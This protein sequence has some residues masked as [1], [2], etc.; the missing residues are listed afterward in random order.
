MADCILVSAASGYRWSPSV[1]AELSTS[2]YCGFAWRP[3]A[4]KGACSCV[5]ALG[6][7]VV[8]AP[9]RLGHDRRAHML[10]DFSLPRAAFSRS[11]WAYSALSMQALRQNILRLAGAAVWNYA[12][13][14]YPSLVFYSQPIFYAQPLA[15]FSVGSSVLV[16]APTRV[17]FPQL[18]HFWRGPYANCTRCRS[19]YSGSVEKSSARAATERHHRFFIKARAACCDIE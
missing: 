1:G 19:A 4:A 7:G 16:R 11:R 14:S 3:L 6:D 8:C 12:L 2:C 5:A 10:S 9:S 18:R 13:A 17:A 15:M